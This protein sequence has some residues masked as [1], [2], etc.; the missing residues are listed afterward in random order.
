MSRTTNVK[1][2][3]EKVLNKTKITY[4]N[5]RNFITSTHHTN[6]SKTSKTQDINNHMQQLTCSE[7]ST[8]INGVA[9]YHV[10]TQRKNMQP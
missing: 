10:D 6:N 1:I 4:N 7:N 3:T 9:N 5:Y 2:I 8:K